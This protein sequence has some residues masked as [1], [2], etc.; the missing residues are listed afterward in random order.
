MQQRVM[1]SKSKGPDTEQRESASAINSYLVATSSRDP[2]VKTPLPLSDENGHNFHVT[3]ILLLGVC[4][5]RVC[6]WGSIAVC[7]LLLK[8]NGK[9]I[10]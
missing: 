2:P 10:V 4:I 5:S 6:S 3:L 7:Y 1:H 8:G 9:N